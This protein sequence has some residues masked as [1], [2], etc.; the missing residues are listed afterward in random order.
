MK[1]IVVQTGFDAK[2][3]EPRYQL[4]RPIQG[5]NPIYATALGISDNAQR[6]LDEALKALEKLNGGMVKR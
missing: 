2:T 6:P 1:W 5:K 3:N 4:A